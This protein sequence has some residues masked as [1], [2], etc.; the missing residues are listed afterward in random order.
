MY[1]SGDISGCCPAEKKAT[2]L[3]TATT[4]ATPYWAIAILRMVA[5]LRPEATV[6]IITQLPAAHA[7]SAT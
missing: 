7:I 5:G 1:S 6:V 4:P 2:R 3:T